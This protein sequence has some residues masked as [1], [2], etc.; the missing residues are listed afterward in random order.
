MNAM[1]DL[2]TTVSS[3]AGKMND[4]TAL[5]G[6]ASELSTRGKQVAAKAETGMKGILSSSSEI[7]H[8]INDISQQMNEIG[9]I[10][11]IISSIAEQTNLLALNAAI[12]AARAGEA[13]LGFAVVAGEV[14]ELATGSQK[15][16]ENIASI[17]STLQKNTSA[18]TSAVQTSLIEVKGGNEA[19]AETLGI[20]NEI[21]ESIA[22][23]DKNMNDVAAASQEQAA[24]VEEVTAT[25]HEFGEMVQ[26]TAKESIGLAAASEESSA[27]VE[28]IV[29]MIT[30]VN[31]SMDEIRQAVAEARESTRHID[32][33]M[34]RFRI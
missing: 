20:F 26:Q 14:K 21:V 25:V 31:T 12:E 11:D 29:T 34:S 19:V 1:Q 13:G 6:T 4:V 18:I 30:N 3:V 10:V 9:R 8:M 15:S 5:T 28:Q 32:E 17:I 7:E 16:A 27:A 2:A 23:I 22:D 24:S 33:E